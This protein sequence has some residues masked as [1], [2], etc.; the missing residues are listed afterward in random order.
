MGETATQEPQE[1]EEAGH[2]LPQLIAE[3]RAK[4]VRLRESD[5]EAFPY[6]FPG[7]E[8]IS[9]ILAGY[10]QLADGE[11]TDDAHRVA[12]RLAARR[13]GGKAAFLDLIDRTGKI[14][15]H[16][17]AEVLGRSPSSAC[18]PSTSAI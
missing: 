15:L 8:P 4:A 9:S 12:G 10:S 13:G 6:S 2:G 18:C 1:P 11:E 3:R 14:Q 7:V 17:R 16:A 5:A